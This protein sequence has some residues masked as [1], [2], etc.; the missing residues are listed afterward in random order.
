VR[1]GGED[2]PWK[3]LFH[4]DEVDLSERGYTAQDATVVAAV[5]AFTA[6][7]TSI[8][9]SR[10]DVGAR[11]S[12]GGALAWALTGLTETD[13]VKASQVQGSSFNV[14]DEVTYKGQKM[15]VSMGKDHDGEIKMKRNTVADL[16]GITALADALRVSAASLTQ[17]NLDGYPLPVKQLKGSD[18]VESINLSGQYLGVA[19]AVVIA[20]LIQGNASLT[21]VRTP[22]HERASLSY[23]H[24]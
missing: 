2:I 16:S 8:D 5:I 17:V 14:G 4:E 24:I 13:Y 10:N 21:S 11:S 12:L 22:A 19:S 9:L 23:V 18:T 1:F 6:S 15:I 3:R 20:S 7:L